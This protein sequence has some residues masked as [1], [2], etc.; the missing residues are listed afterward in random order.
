[1]LQNYGLTEKL[2]SEYFGYATPNAFYNS[3]ARKRIVKGI[4]KVIKHIETNKIPT[5]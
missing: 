2:I 1:M 4:I 3:S 5:H